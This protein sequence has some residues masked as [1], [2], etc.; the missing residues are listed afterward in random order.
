MCFL[1]NSGLEAQLLGSRNQPAGVAVGNDKDCCRL[2][3]VCPSKHIHI[4]VA[5]RR[6]WIHSLL[7]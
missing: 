5:L 6:L 4:P 1:V 7:H 3:Y 2:Q